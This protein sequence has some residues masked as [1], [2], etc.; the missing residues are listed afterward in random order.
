VIY[1][2]SE[3]AGLR[4]LDSLKRF[5]TTQL[6]LKVS[7]KK[8]A[9]ARPSRRTFLG[10]IVTT[11]GQLRVSMQSRLR[12]KQKLRQLFRGAQGRSLISTI[13]QL[14]LVLRGWSAYFKLAPAVTPFET[15]D[16]WV[17][18]RLR[19]LLWRQWKRPR[20]RER[21]LR[22][23]GLADERAWRSSVNG[24][25]PWW[26]AGAS[27]MNQALPK[28]RFDHWGLVSVRDTTLRLQRLS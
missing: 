12:L 7:D 3:R 5:I 15:I 6:K 16:G 10:Y 21:Y 22:R 8:S 23:Y 13:G 27:H 20:T 17:R 11:G 2:K 26:N 24:R 28:A 14:N 25:G 19:C 4:V 1:V 9:V 18:R